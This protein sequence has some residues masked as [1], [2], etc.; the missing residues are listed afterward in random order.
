MSDKRSK[1][2]PGFVEI[3]GFAVRPLNLRLLLLFE[4][5]KSGF[6]RPTR[7]DSAKEVAVEA[8]RFVWIVSEECEP[9]RG[10]LH[11]LLFRWRRWHFI[12]RIRSVGAEKTIDEI[13]RYLTGGFLDTPH[14]DALASQFA[15]QINARHVEANRYLD[16]AANWHAGRA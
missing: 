2:D 11:R 3:A 8:A 1:S 13:H 16:L 6:V 15:A 12:R 9:P 4:E 10:L 14:S 7:F 5:V